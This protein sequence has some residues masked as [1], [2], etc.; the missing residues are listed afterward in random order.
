MTPP[1][2]AA[3]LRRRG[4]DVIAVVERA[5]LRS[6]PDREIFA[7]AQTEDRVIVTRDRADYLRIERE[8][9]AAGRAHAGLILISSRFPAAAVGA[10]GCRARW[11]P[12]R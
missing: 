11:V 7:F 12:R 4:R 10:C 6:L 8:E 1:T 5:E 9:R 2:V 3:Q